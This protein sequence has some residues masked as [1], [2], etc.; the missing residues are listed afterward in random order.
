M[1][2]ANFAII[3]RQP[4]ELESRIT[5]HHSWLHHGLST[6]PNRVRHFAVLDGLSW[7]ELGGMSRSTVSTNC[8]ISVSNNQG[9]G[10]QFTGPNLNSFGSSFNRVGGGWYV[11]QKTAEDGISV[12]FWSRMD[13]SVPD[14]VVSGRDSLSPNPSWGLPSAAFPSTSCNYASHF[15]AHEIIFDLT[16][17]VSVFPASQRQSRLICTIS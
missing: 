7:I 2:S 13:S 1:S 14:E 8:D 5:A 11:M 16:F 4:A 9:C 3:R 17:C 15:N 12:W 6:S 10:T